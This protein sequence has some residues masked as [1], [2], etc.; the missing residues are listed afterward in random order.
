[1]ES[2]TTERM[3]KAYI[4]MRDARAVLKTEYESKDASI[5][6][7]MEM[8]EREFMQLCNQAGANS[9]NIA[10]AGTIIRGTKSRYWTNDWDAMKSFIRENEVLDLFEQRLHQ[11]NI[12]QFLQEH[13]DKHP[14]GL[15]VETEY[16]IT[17]RRV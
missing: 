11:K 4:K 3:V 7:K 5:K 9:L 12:K 17:V 8:L 10:G 13:P 16:T 2:V 14:P 6:E 15:N 1:M